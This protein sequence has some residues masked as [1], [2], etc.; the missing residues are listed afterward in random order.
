MKYKYVGN[1]SK[2]IAEK[3]EILE[4]SGKKIIVY[5]DRIKHVVEKHYND[6]ENLNALMKAYYAIPYVIKNP[7]FCFYNKKTKGLEY[8]KN[9]DNNLCVVVRINAGKV[10]KIRSW[11]PANKGKIKNRINQLKTKV[12]I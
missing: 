2:T 3:C 12:N 9:L 4:H 8:Y 7:D 10:L 11:Y 5:E 6:F 1:L